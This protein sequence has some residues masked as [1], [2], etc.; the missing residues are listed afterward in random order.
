MNRETPALSRM[1]RVATMKSVTVQW[2]SRPP[3]STTRPSLRVDIRPEFAHFPGA[4]SPHLRCVTASVTIGTL[5][6]DTGP[7]DRTIVARTRLR[8][9]DER[10]EF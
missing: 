5:R 4:R 9:L 6:D 3:P 8:A 7:R 1:F 10:P 2:F